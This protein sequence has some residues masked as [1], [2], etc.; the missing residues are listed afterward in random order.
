[1][2]LEKN[3][4]TIDNL[5][6]IN[7]EVNQTFKK[8]QIMGLVNLDISKAYDSTWRHN[9]LVELN[10]ILCKGKTLNL[11]TN[12]L[13]DRT[14]EVKANNYLSEEHLRQHQAD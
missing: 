6:Q 10:Q 9:I 1:M 12:F 7:Q 2:A 3:K 5:I 14:F 4:S 11:I 8:K 13:K